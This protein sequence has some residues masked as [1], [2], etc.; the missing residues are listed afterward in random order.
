MISCFWSNSDNRHVIIVISNLEAPII[1]MVLSVLLQLD[2]LSQESLQ[3]LEPASEHRT[4]LCESVDVRWVVELFLVADVADEPLC[5]T[6]A[7]L[8]EWII[9]LAMPEVAE[10]DDDIVDFI[11]RVICYTHWDSL[12]QFKATAG[13]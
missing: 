13:S 9:V 7:I 11:H 8:R 10:V 3:W 4:Q 6:I 5:K 1:D 2:H 12:L